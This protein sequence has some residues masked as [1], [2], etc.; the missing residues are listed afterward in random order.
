MKLFM[1]TKTLN[2]LDEAAVAMGWRDAKE[3]FGVTMIVLM[4]IL[5]DDQI[6]N[7]DYTSARNLLN[8]N[9]G[10]MVTFNKDWYLNN[11]ISGNNHYVT[12]S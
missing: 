9:R 11:A 3:M 7:G 8:K 4:D 2:K 10:G 5:K 1:N 6:I 12:T